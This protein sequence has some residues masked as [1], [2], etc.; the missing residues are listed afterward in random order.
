MIQNLL[1]DNC[2]LSTINCQ[3][4]LPHIKQGNFMFLFYFK[5]SHQV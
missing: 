4:K 2:Q 5:I 1:T 3:L